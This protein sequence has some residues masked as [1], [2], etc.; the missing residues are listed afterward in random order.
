MRE[1]SR[2]DSLNCGSLEEKVMKETRT[3]LWRIKL[4]FVLSDLSADDNPG[5]EIDDRDDGIGDPATDIVKVDIHSST[6]ELQE[7]SR[8]E[9]GVM[10]EVTIVDCT[11]KL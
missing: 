8:E 11:I 4:A 10:I 9:R 6:S 3:K 1:I 5:S 7:M 2:K